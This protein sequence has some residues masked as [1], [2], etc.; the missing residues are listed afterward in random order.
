MLINKIKEVLVT[1]RPVGLDDMGNTR[2]MNRVDTKY[3][4][5]IKKVPA[6]LTEMDGAYRVLDIQNNRIFSYYTTYLDTDDF[7]FYNQHVTGRLGRNKVRYRKYQTTGLTY[8]EVK[9]KT[10]KNRTIKWRIEHNPDPGNECDTTACEF[11]NEYLP[12]NRLELKP[13]LISSFNRITLVGSE[14]NERIT[15]DRDLTYI[16]LDGNRMSFPFFTIIEHKRE[17]FANGS[18]I[19]KILKANQIHP[20]GFSK[21]CF[22]TALMNENIPRKNMLKPKFLLINK[23]QDEFNKP[24]DT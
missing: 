2:L 4:V 8:L 21:Y 24:S 14:I 1:F 18:P 11:I 20:T 22:G 6:I 9:R 23:I 5:S 13:V 17:R 7:L 16:D 10:N 15:I 12:Q 3:L 19:T